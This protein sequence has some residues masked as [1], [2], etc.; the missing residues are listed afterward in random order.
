M[1]RKMYLFSYFLVILVW[2]SGFTQSP[3]SVLVL[4]ELIQEAVENNPQLQAGFHNW[5][6]SEVR[7]PQAGAL[8]D[9]M[10]GINLLNMPV[11]N[12]VFDREPMSGKQISLTQLFPFPGKL[13]LKKA[14]AREAAAVEQARY[15]ELR[16]R[17]IRDVRQTY[18]DL[19]HVDKAIETVEKNRILL[20]QF[21]SIAGARY[22]V[23]KGLQ[24][25]VLK[26]Q[27]EL[28]RL[29]DK[30]ITLRQKRE[31]LEAR[32]NALLNRPAGAAIGK[33]GEPDIVQFDYTLSDL[34][35]L[36][37]ENRPLLK[38]WQALQR[39]SREKVKLAK[40]EYFPDFKIG[41]AYTQ[42]DVLKNGGGGTD[43]LS[44]MFSTSVP[45]YFWKKQRKKL[46]ESRL[47]LQS[48]E[49]NYSN[50]RNQVYAALDEKLNDI[51]KNRRLLDLYRNGIIPQ[52]TQALNSAISAYQTDRVDFLTLLNN[53]MTL[54]N[55]QLDYYQILSDYMKTIADLEMLT[56]TRLVE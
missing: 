19:F 45:L 47:M 46:E 52:A 27:V 35:A 34:K 43:Y 21:V 55:Y 23:G 10:L 5:K 39:Q 29:I 15:Q 3:D 56:G 18:Y 48:V 44:G 31:M 49:A 36:A 30:K 16:Q 50:V 40:R 1:K 20:D 37:E 38:A 24:Q 28:S 53:Q 17:L 2:N 14:I 54:F 33:P 26:A 32:L 11:N 22:S 41:V 7:I 42:R 25:D 4:E 6:S 13:G 12:L 9:P 8:P 51:R